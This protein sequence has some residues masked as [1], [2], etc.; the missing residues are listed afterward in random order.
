[1]TQYVRVKQANKTR[2]S[3]FCC[4]CFLALGLSSTIFTLIIFGSL[5]LLSGIGPGYSIDALKPEY[6]PLEIVLAV[7]MGISIVVLVFPPSRID[8]FVDWWHGIGD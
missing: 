5:A 7:I 6:Y 3:S 1:M 8:R 4:S 2:G